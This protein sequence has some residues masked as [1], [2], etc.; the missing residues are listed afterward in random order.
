MVVADVNC[1]GEDGYADHENQR[2]KLAGKVTHLSQKR[3]GQS[4]DSANKGADV[5]ELAVRSGG[6]GDSS[7][8]SASDEGP[9]E[10]H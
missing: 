3:C 10:R 7:P 4:L 8:I 9:R 1:K 5:A 2:R 6:Y